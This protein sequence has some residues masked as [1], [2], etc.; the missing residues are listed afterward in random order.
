LPEPDFCQFALYQDIDELRAWQL[1]IK[2]ADIVI[3]GSYVPQ[4]VAIAAM[5]RPWSSILAFYDIDTPV[6]LARLATGNCEY[7]TAD[8]IP[9]FDIYLS[10]T[11][12]PILNVLERHYGARAARPL[13]CAADPQRYRPAAHTRPPKWALGYLGTYSPDRQPALERLLLQPARLAPALRFVVA[14]PQYPADIDWP[15]NVDRIEHL[16]PADHRDFYNCLAWTLNITR[17]DM[18]A[19]GHSPSV[20]V[21]EAAACATPIISDAWPGLGDIF[22]IGIEIELAESA[23]D[24]LEIL[25][26]PA[27]LSAKMGEAARQRV[28]AEHTADH[29][30]R[31]LE[32]YIS[33]VSP[34]ARAAS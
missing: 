13:F 11:A 20:R 8:T 23:S 3:I 7:L 29:R 31:A 33:E 1:H 28:L 16:P 4:A 2:R 30:A 14:G 17:A 5:L 19:S 15:D 10:F 12:G 18:L 25:R 34:R 9:S 21:F 6:T 32:T 27:A 24:I 22:E 26:R